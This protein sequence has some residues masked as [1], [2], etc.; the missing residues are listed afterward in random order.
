MVKHLFSFAG[1]GLSIK[2]APP[3][4]ATS[5]CFLELHKGHQEML[6]GFR[7]L[8]HF[9]K[10]FKPDLQAYVS[11]NSDEYVRRTKPQHKTFLTCEE[12]CKNVYHFLG[13]PFRIIESTDTDHISKILEHCGEANI[14]WYT[15]DEYVGGMF[16]EHH[17]RHKHVVANAFQFIDKRIDQSSTTQLKGVLW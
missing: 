16:N 15:T 1:Q 8:F 5:G 4:L 11:V 10:I 17:S 14:I 12:R 6:S 9:L 3:V 7:E 13:N 2:N